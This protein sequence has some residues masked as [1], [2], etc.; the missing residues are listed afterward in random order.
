MSGDRRTVIDASSLLSGDHDSTASYS[1][2]SDLDRP[3][4]SHDG[5]LATLKSWWADPVKRRYI[6][7]IGLGVLTFLIIVAVVAIITKEEVKKGGGNQGDAAS[8]STANGGGGNVG[9]STGA[10]IPP[11]STAAV[12]P[13]FNPETPWLFPRLPDSTT[14]SVSTPTQHHQPPRLLSLLCPP[15]F[16]HHPSHPC[17]CVCRTTLCS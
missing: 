5:S 1:N 10:L 6:V 3:S 2:A 11:S 16:S 12:I 9:S 8:S 7:G 4:S 15:P 13:P 14:A 17:V